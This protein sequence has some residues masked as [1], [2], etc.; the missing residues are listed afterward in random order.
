MN[1]CRWSS[2]AATVISCR[3]SMDNVDDED[4]DDHI[5]FKRA[6][7][8]GER[9]VFAAVSS[10]QQRLWRTEVNGRTS[11]QTSLK[12]W[13]FNLLVALITLEDQIRLLCALV[14]FLMTPRIKI[15]S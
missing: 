9:P 13:A 4:G 15:M 10:I 1:F 5:I 14:R 8:V 2:S 3:L 11:L 7:A 6:V 12:L